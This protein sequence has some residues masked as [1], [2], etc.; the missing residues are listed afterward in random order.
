VDGTADTLFRKAEKLSNGKKGYFVTGAPGLLR[1]NSGRWR[2][3]E[4]HR[5]ILELYTR[6]FELEPL[7]TLSLYRR[8]LEKLSVE[9]AAGAE[10]DFIELSRIGSPYASGL[11]PIKVYLVMGDLKK[12][13]EYLDRENANNKAKGIPK[14]KI[15]DFEEYG[16]LKSKSGK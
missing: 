14:Y 12:A 8:A 2:S 16:R 10:A 11:L 6:V 13:N 15:T 5:E 9:D 3:Q 7:D 1:H 4:L